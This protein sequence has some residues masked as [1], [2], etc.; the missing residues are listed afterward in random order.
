MSLCLSEWAAVTDDAVIS[1]CTEALTVP[2]AAFLL[3]TLPKKKRRLSCK[4]ILWLG[5]HK[6][7]PVLLERCGLYYLVLISRM[8]PHW[9]LLTMSE[10]SAAGGRML[11]LGA[12]APA[13]LFF[14][15][16]CTCVSGF[17]VV[18]LSGENGRTWPG[19][20]ALQNWKPQKVQFQ[21]WIVQLPKGCWA[22]DG[23]I[24]VDIIISPG[25]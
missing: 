24:S 12:E 22:C 14:L 25:P 4:P 13:S 21:V 15:I 5:Y 3:M 1:S 6:C 16:G 18:E 17:K 23:R 11:G 9:L 19:A 2:F 8:F 10:F 20:A 7:L